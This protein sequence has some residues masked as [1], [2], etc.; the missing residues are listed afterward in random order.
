[1]KGFD[2]RMAALFES[3]D[4]SGAPQIPLSRPIITD[5]RER[6]RILMFLAGGELV[7][8]TGY[9]VDQLDPVRGE[10]VPGSIVTD[11]EWIWSRACAYYLAEHGVAP[12]V[13]FLN[14]IRSRRYVPSTPDRKSLALAEQLLIGVTQLPTLLT[15]DQ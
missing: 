7:V 15:T 5:P 8:T 12:E 11:G 6:R 4:S 14:Y 9:T 1:M 10:V 13:E 2:M 3:V